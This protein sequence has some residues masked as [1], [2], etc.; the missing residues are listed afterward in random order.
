MFEDQQTRTG[1]PATAPAPTRIPPP[2]IRTPMSGAG[3]PDILSEAPKSAPTPPRAMPPKR[4]GRKIAL[5]FL[6]VI[7][8]IL[9]IVGGVLAY[10]SFLRQAPNANTNLPANNVN[11]NVNEIVNLNTNANVNGNENANINEN[12]NFVQPPPAEIV[13]GSDAD[14]DGLTDNQE[15]L[16]GTNKDNPDTD[17]DTY[18]DGAE[19]EGLFDPTKVGGA[20]LVDSDLVKLYENQ[21]FGYSVLYPSKWEAINSADNRTVIFSITPI[22]MEAPLETWSEET[23]EISL[24]DN[25]ARDPLYDWLLRKEPNVM[26]PDYVR[27]LSK[28]NFDYLSSINGFTNYL[29]KEG[30]L[31]KIYTFKYEVGANKTINNLST[32]RMM[33]NSFSLK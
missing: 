22:A 9:L 19:L 32:L 3:S 25:T 2:P 33:I 17:G 18:L 4:G 12:L 31:D 16:Y 24:E 20:L 11:G 26:L 30:Q 5:V 14:F 15:D 23:I 21:T 7:I 8:A 13:F 6:I 1:A 27:Q 28:G 29:T 10:F